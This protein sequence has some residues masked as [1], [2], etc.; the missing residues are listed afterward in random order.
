MSGAKERIALLFDLDRMAGEEAKA[1][2]QLRDMQGAGGAWSWFGGMQ[3]SPYIT[4]HIVA[5]FGHLEALGAAD[6]A[7]MARCKAC[8][9]AP[10]G[11]WT[12]TCA[13]GTASSRTA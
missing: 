13:N 3:P 2:Q 7:R 1:L 8:S 12:T 11:G 9:S 10:S 4:R 5:G 6:L